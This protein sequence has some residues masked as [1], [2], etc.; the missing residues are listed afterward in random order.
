MRMILQRVKSAAVSVDGNEISRIGFG[1][2]VLVGIE[3]GDDQQT[4]RLAAEKLSTLRIFQ[5][6]NGRMNLAADRAHAE[7]LIVSQFTLAASLDRGRRPSFD[8]AAAPELAA[9]LVDELARRIREQGLIAK[10]G[11]FGSYMQVAL[12]N[13]GPVTFV[14]DL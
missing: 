8:R 12:V 2:L 4:V 6:Q 9:P 5:N 14:V 11:R 10:E 7:F 13:D 3:Q 1:A